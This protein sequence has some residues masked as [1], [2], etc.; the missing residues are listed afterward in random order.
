MRIQRTRARG[1]GAIVAAL[2][3]LAACDGQ[4]ERDRQTTG[5]TAGSSRSLADTA[6]TVTSSESV[7]TTPT[8]PS[9]LREP[10]SEWT[11]TPDSFGDLAINFSTIRQESPN[12]WSGW[13][14]LLPHP[15]HTEPNG[16][17]A[18]KLLWHVVANCQ[19]GQIYVR[20]HADYDSF[21]HLVSSEDFSRETPEWSD[22]VPKTNGDDM[23]QRLCDF[24]DGM[25]KAGKARR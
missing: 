20:S 17:K 3:V 23:L 9:L 10:D 12:V 22:P 6:V 13:Y 7:S 21:G 19:K 8:A 2:A 4:A 15:P 1:V 18:V 11:A 14:R 25:V 24:A 5:S 16:K